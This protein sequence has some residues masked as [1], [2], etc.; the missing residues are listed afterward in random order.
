MWHESIFT[1]RYCQGRRAGLVNKPTD[2]VPLELT[3]NE[4]RAY[5][6]HLEGLTHREIGLQL[7][8]HPDSIKRILRKAKRK[9]AEDHRQVA[10]ATGLFSSPEKAATVI[11]GLTEPPELRKTHAEIAAE[12]GVSRDTVTRANKKLNTRLSVL[13][14]ELEDVKAS[15]LVQMTGTLG[16]RILESIDQEDIDKASLAQKM[17]AFGISV[18][19]W[20]VLSGKP[21]RIYTVEDRRSLNEITE[22]LV[23]EARRRGMDDIV[24]VPH[25]DVSEDEEHR[26]TKNRSK[27]SAAA[28]PA[29]QARTASHRPADG[30]RLP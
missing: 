28:P 17:V 25:T 9:L 29:G 3:R 27:S 15:E 14:G 5:D 24:D 26:R 20:N 10:P 18:D 16:K 13:K 7:G 6:L 11:D 12:A 21:S 1:R 8:L 30:L 23:A 4:T 19:K 22:A 2:T